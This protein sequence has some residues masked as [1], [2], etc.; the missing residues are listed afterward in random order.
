MAWGEGGIWEP[1]DGAATTAAN[2]G[3]VNFELAVQGSVI[4][5]VVQVEIKEGE[6]WSTIAANLAKEW[7][8]R[9]PINL[10][11]GPLIGK[12]FANAQGNVTAFFPTDDLA[13]EDGNGNPLHPVLRMGVTF[14]GQSRKALN[15]RGESDTWTAGKVKLTWL[16]VNVT[17]DAGS[18][19]QSGG[20]IIGEGEAPAPRGPGGSKK[21]RSTVPSGAMR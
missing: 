7:N 16:K 8:D 17:K 21:P 3:Q 10:T 12:V 15:N 20:S 11:S 14:P 13:K 1:G 5:G 2:D 4:T 9:M 18:A 19:S 6:S